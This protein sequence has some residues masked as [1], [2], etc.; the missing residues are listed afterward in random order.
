MAE[1]AVDAPGGAFSGSGN[2]AV[3][4]TP[5]GQFS[6]EGTGGTIGAGLNDSILW[7]GPAPPVSSATQFVLW[8]NTSDGRWYGRWNDGT[9]T[10]WV[11]LS[12]PFG[13][14][15]QGPIGLVGD[16]GD[17]GDTGQGIPT[18]GL[19][20]EILVKLDGTDY[21]TVWGA[22]PADGNTVLYDTVDPTTEG[23]DGDFFINTTTDFLFGPKAGGTWPAGTSLVGPT[24][25][26]G[27]DYTGINLETESSGSH[28][29]DDDDFNGEKRI[30]MDNASAQTVTLDDDITSDQP[31]IYDQFGAGQITFVAGG[32]TVIYSADSSLKSRVQY[33]AIVVQPLGA[34]FFSI[35]GDIT[36]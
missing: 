11:D 30:S 21:N 14:G 19:T 20:N 33:S 31:I 4:I 7:I 23:A 18:G 2:T 35:S 24:G 32:T 3:G 1:V 9:S 36:S 22:R 13:E 16:K 6:G 10:Q 26:D 27:T 12:L 29:P 15:K 34:G 8:I 17:K 25:A 28:T 5:G